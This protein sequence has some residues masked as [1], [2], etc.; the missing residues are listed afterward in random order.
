MTC[1]GADGADASCNALRRGAHWAAS[2]RGLDALV[3]TSAVNRCLDETAA[4]SSARD[5]RRKWRWPGRARSG[6]VLG[7]RRVVGGARFQG[8]GG[9]R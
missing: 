9:A 4:G 6:E 8:G 2:S 7:G 3:L 5:R 1:A